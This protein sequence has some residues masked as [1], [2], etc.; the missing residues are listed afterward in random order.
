MFID[1]FLSYYD[2]MIYYCLFQMASSM[3]ICTFISA[4]MMFLSAQV[5]SFNK[6]Y[7]DQLKKFGFDLSI[8]ALIGALWVLLVFTLTKKYKRMPHRLT[9]CLIVSQVNLKLVDCV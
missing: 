5:I 9:L 2:N 7:N 6:D 4:P 3:V 8:V 1:S